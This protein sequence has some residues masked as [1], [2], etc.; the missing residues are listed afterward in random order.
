MLKMKLYFDDVHVDTCYAA[1][2]KEAYYMKRNLSGFWDMNECCIEHWFNELK[3]PFEPQSINLFFDIEDEETKC[4]IIL[5]KI[6]TYYSYNYTIIDNTIILDSSI[7]NNIGLKKIGYND[8]INGH[9]EFSKVEEALIQFLDNLINTNNLSIEDGTTPHWRENIIEFIETLIPKRI[10]IE[11][12]DVQELND[13]LKNMGCSFKFKLCESIIPGKNTIE[14]IPSSSI[15]ISSSIINLTDD[16]YKYLEDF[17]YMKGIILNT[18]NTG[19]V[20]WANNI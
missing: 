7:V 15:F 8:I 3:R 1:N 9:F 13:N 17:F 11:K 20:F 12:K 10:D 4:W 18:N 14:V 6:A 5:D 19:T 16:F 2:I